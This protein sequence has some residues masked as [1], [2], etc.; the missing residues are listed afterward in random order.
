ML[1]NIHGHLGVVGPYVLKVVVEDTVPD[2]GRLCVK[3]KIAFLLLRVILP[4][5]NIKSVTGIIA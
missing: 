1:R 3:L 4:L 2:Q 5:S